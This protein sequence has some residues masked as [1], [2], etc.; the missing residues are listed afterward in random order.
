MFTPVE[1][2]LGALLIQAATTSYMHYEG[3]AIGFSSILYNSIFKPTVH[4]ISI[5]TGLFLSSWF[6]GYFLPIFKSSTVPIFPNSSNFHASPIMFLAAGV[7][8]GLGTS[9][10]CGCTSGHMLIG[11]SR[12]RWRSFIATCTFFTTSV[13]TTMTTGTYKSINL[14]TTPNYYY[15]PHFTVFQENMPKLLGL[16]ILGQIWS[17]SVMPKV[18][19]W[20]KANNNQ[21]NSKNAQMLRFIFGVSSGFL[22]GCGLF[23]AGMTDPQ[24]VIGFLSFLSPHYF[25]PSLAM[26]PLFCI[27]PNIFIW[28][29]WIPNSKN[30]AIAS[31][32][33]DTNETQIKKPLFEPEYDLNFSN[34]VDLKFLLGN[35]LFGIG[36]GLSGV[37]PGPGILTMFS[38]FNELVLGRGLLYIVGFL[39]GQYVQKHV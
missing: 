26:I 10:G 12:L 5:I 20:L 39:G 19:S 22:F 34:Q 4:S 7:L 27:V 11:M 2:A 29:R 14:S 23:I 17:Y 33:K 25:D 36:W 8:V 38:E 21:F 32:A 28:R 16:V 24:K 13:L 3:K 9:A 35:A 31:V 18:G 6:I 30:E 15:D 37:C 1:S